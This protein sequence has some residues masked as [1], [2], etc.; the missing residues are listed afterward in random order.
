MEERRKNK[1]IEL[2]S[3][4]IIKRL[5]AGAEA[6]EEV[7]IEIVDVSK[8]GVGFNCTIPLEIGAVYEA[9]LTI[10]TKEVS[11]AFL[12]IV[13]IMKESGIGYGAVNHPVDRDPVCGYVGVI[14]DVCPKCGRKEFEGVPMERVTS[15]EDIC[16][17]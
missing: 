3:R 17:E 15:I 13:R 16:C 12:E 14:N 6:A 5:D 8:T 2:E 10:W 4:L 9:Y 1:R 7:A 11:H